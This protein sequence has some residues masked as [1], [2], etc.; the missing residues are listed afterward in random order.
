MGLV[1]A[2]LVLV[3]CGLAASGVMVTSIL[4]HSLISRI[5]Q[6]LLDAS[7]SWAQAPRK[8]SPPPYEGP[9]PGRPPSKFYVRGIGIDG[10]P[11]TAINDRNAEPALPADNDV[12][13]NPVTLPSVNGSEIQWR[14]VSVRGPHGLITVAIDL[15]DLEHTVRSLVWL[16]VGIG[17]AVLVV[18]GLAGFAVVQRSLR[19]LAEV[20]Q[21]AAAIASGQLDRRVPERDP[22]TEVGRLSLALNGMLTQIQRAMA[23]SESS[24][25]KAR[26]SEERMRRFI[27]DASHE[28]R[29]PLTTIRGFAELYRQG[30][31]RDVAMLLSR[32]ESEAS[33][34]GL[35]VDD[36]LLL[37]RLDVQRPLE[38]H[39]V[40]LLALA[41]DAVHDAQAIDP[42]RRVYMEVLDGP[43]TPEVLGD[44]P[45]I[46]QVLSNLVANAL[47]HTPTSADVIV[48]VGTEGD[49]AVIEVADRG[50]GMTQQD[51]SRIFER[52]YRTDSS[53]ARASGG[54]GLG[55]SI[56]D[57]LVHAHGGAVSVKTAPGE[58]CCFRVTLPRISE[59]P[60]QVG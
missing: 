2:T 21:T 4:R 33:R 16:Q 34:M 11:F 53:R 50:P 42:Q 45:R 17:V 48:R 9:D 27:T 51:A 58:G 10:T 3:A 14:A 13:P 23:S 52:F 35:L 25:E 15:S 32:I 56:V 39:R 31:A 59:V 20:E 24:A 18:V 43:G 8:Q 47:Q 49:D 38:H 1:A 44:E 19:P 6:T 28:L 36:L 40:D 5:D 55:L 22:R 54:T 30:A 46:R 60:A 29:T 7:K 57:S 37:A 12:G 26:G 41:S